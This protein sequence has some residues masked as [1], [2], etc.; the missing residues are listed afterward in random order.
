M[1]TAERHAEDMI[2]NA[3]HSKA[4]LL[5][6]KGNEIEVIKASKSL[7]HSVIVDEGFLQVAAHID[8]NLKQK[9]QRFKYVD[10]SCL[11][12]LDKVLQ[13]EDQRLTFINKGG[14]PF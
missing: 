12:P 2:R 13:Q 6:T 1:E 14:S 5:E 8:S 3:E 9:I 7:L 11:L 10:F 4:Q